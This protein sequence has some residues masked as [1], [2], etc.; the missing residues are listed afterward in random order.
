MIT[1]YPILDG[2]TGGFAKGNLITIVG[3]TL[4]GR[5]MFTM[6]ILR[7]QLNVDAFQNCIYDCGNGC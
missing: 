1:G 6:N 7:N 2:L 3:G 5:T 4:T